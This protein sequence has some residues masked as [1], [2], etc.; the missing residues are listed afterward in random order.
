M[1]VFSQHCVQC[2]YPSKTLANYRVPLAAFHLLP[3]L[4]M[5]YQFGCSTLVD[6]KDGPSLCWG[7][8]I[9]ETYQIF[10]HSGI[11]ALV[12]LLLMPLRVGLIHVGVLAF[13]MSLLYTTEGTL[14]LGSKWCSYC[15]VY[16]I[17]YLI[18][19][20]WAPAT[21]KGQVDAKKSK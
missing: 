19:P 14:A 5:M 4:G 1:V 18:D 20:Y 3:I 11:V 13:V 17:M 8:V 2:F 9:A 12:F 21:P 16:S 7:N 10:I 15:L 6:S